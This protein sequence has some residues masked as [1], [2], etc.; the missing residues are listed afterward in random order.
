MD[1]A[2]SS[3]K[4]PF[5]PGDFTVGQWVFVELGQDPNDPNEE[6]FTALTQ[7]VSLADNAV[8]VEASVPYDVING[9]SMHRITAVDSLATDVHV[10]DVKFDHVD[11]TIP[12]S[13]IWIGITRNSSIDGVSGRFNMVLN[14]SDSSNIQLKN[15]N[16][17][18]VVGHPAA[19]RVFTA[20]QSNNVLVSDVYA[21]TS[22][23]KAVFFIES[24]SRDTTF[25]NINVRWRYA[26]TPRGAVFHLTGGSSGTFVDQLRI[27]NTGLVNLVGQGG[28]L[29][30]FKFGTVSISGGVHTVP[31]F[32]T[33]DLTIGTRRY[34]QTL[35]LTKTID[36]VAGWSDYR[37]PLVA[38]TIKSIK[39]TATDK[40][41]L[42]YVLVI[43]A[44][45]N[46]CD[47][48]KALVSGATINVEWKLGFLGVVYPV[49]DAVES[50]KSLT[51]Y[52]P[53][54]IMPGSR[55]TVEVEYYP[56]TS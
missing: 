8:T 56:A 12:A 3:G 2:P 39:V 49:N 11:G 54:S 45:G 27:D 26:Q 41:S 13:A 9:A 24:W 4:R 46:G 40:A 36:L 53:A 23:D 25:R 32:L 7:I 52:T 10:R 20:W 18:V 50:M 33:D 21:D 48:T 42:N 55:L 30:D 35:Q 51:L 34:A 38:A 19:G 28:Q 31:L 1:V 5:A 15:V 43:N 47:L 16:A 17:T 44:N 14:V 6:H 22:A 37:I 29:S